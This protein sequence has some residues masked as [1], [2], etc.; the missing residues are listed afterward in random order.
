[1]EEKDL[2]VG[3]GLRRVIGGVKVGANAVQLK[4]PAAGTGGGQGSGEVKLVGFEVSW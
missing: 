4:P 1:M 2:G 3:Y